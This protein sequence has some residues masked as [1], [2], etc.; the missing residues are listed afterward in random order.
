MFSRLVV[1]A[2]LAG[3]ASVVVLAQEN[4]VV[5]GSSHDHYFIR[6]CGTDGRN[7][8]EH[9]TVEENPQ[10]PRWSLLGVSRD[11]AIAT[12]ELPEG[13]SPAAAAT[14]GSSLVILALDRHPHKVPP[15]S[16]FFDMF[17]FDNQ[18]NLLSQQRVNID[19]IPSQMAV[20][21][22]GKT[23]LVGNYHEPGQ[24]DEEKHVAAIMDTDGQV[25]KRIPF[26]LPPQGGG[27][28]L[29]TYRLVAG[30]DAAYMVL[31]SY[32]PPATGIA[33]ISE[34]GRIDV[35]IVQ[36]APYDDVRHHNAWL[37]GPGVAVEEYHMVGKTR[38][39]GRFDEYDLNTGEKIATKGSSAL[40]GGCYTGSE[41]TTLAA[42]FHVDPS[43]HLSPDTL[44]LVFSKLEEL[45]LSP[46]AGH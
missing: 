25:I 44:R 42:S 24:D 11:G 12:F 29:V 27:W 1:A 35:K 46:P 13:E 23:I 20:L 7:F 40:G 5:I 26:P 17:R 28:T 34:T 21:P 8:L 36:D 9:D 6:A 43:R 39:I 33:K 19:F 10:S 45:P 16:P 18:A 38:P 41:I 4:D 37:L 32:D 2:L 14:D 30:E 15:N 3:I 31:H 22:S